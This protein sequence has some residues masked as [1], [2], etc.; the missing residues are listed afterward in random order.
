MGGVDIADQLISYY[1]MSFRSKKYYHRFIFHMFD[2]VRVNGWLLFRMAAT[3]MQ[4]ST[5]KQM[6]LCEFKLK[7]SDALIICK[8]SL[9]KK[10]GRPSFVETAYY[11]KKV[12]RIFNQKNSR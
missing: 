1:R 12:K 10:R 2:V 9:V 6:S 4:V 3:K 7:I 11:Q 8:K 5:R